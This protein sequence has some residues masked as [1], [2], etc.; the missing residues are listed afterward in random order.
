MSD[1]NS[2]ALFSPRSEKIFLYVP[3]VF[4]VAALIE[5]ILTG[6]AHITALGSKDLV[7]YTMDLAAQIFFLNFSHTGLTILLIHSFPEFNTWIK[8]RYSGGYPEYYIRMTIIFLLSFAF[9]YAP[10]W[11][12][13]PLQLAPL[14]VILMTYHHG[15]MQMRGLS[16]TYNYKILQYEP[17]TEV[18]QKIA[19]IDKI[20]KYAFYGLLV[21]HIGFKSL[22]NLR[23]Q[24]IVREELFVW[25][26]F[27]YWLLMPLLLVLLTYTSYATNKIFKTNKFIYLLRTLLFPISI[28]SSIGMLGFSFY[29]G[30]EYYFVFDKMNKNSN[31]S[32]K[33]KKE[34][35]KDALILMVLLGLLA[36]ALY[37]ASYLYKVHPEMVPVE[38]VAFL[39]AVVGALSNL[40]RYQDRIIF[41]MRDQNT[42]ENIAP[43]LANS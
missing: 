41:R 4:I 5:I 36:A 10:W 15:I 37:V 18:V 35:K 25:I 13:L 12:Q 32:E 1:V 39:L 42:R 24:G 33:R 9:L 6:T 43:L 22:E 11:S 38:A 17:Q 28:F 16:A 8:R 19:R 31:S 2:A 30:I 40:H 3:L 21:T 29:H 20:E 34:I 14:F 23:F 26:K 27:L 7:Y